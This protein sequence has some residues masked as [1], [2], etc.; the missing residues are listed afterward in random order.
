MMEENARQRNKSRE[1]PHI[2]IVRQQ[3]NA[4][5]ESFFFWTRAR[6]HVLTPFSVMEA[7]ARERVSIAHI[8]TYII[9]IY[10]YGDAEF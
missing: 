1:D 5:E 6:V 10:I 9:Y 8:P 7:R 4:F 3:R 2:M